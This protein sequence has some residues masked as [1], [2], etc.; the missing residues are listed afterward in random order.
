MDLP[1]YWFIYRNYGERSCA[2]S[3][4]ILPSIL[5]TIQMQTKALSYR[6][7]WP[8]SEYSLVFRVEFDFLVYW[9]LRKNNQRNCLDSERSN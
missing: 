6:K 9:H 8:L 7:H 5:L 1:K 4:T 2:N 3:W